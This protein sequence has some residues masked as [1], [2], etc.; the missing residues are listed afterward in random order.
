MISRGQP[1][2]VIMD[3]ADLMALDLRGKPAAFL[4]GCPVPEFLGYPFPAGSVVLDPWH[5][6]GPVPGVDIRYVGEQR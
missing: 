6:L 5:R 1:L 3:A 4:L 2:T